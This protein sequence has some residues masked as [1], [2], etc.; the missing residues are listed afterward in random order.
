MVNTM[1]INDIDCHD[2]IEIGNHVFNHY[3]YTFNQDDPY[4]VGDLQKFLGN[5]GLMKIGKI[6]SKISDIIE[7]PF[8]LVEVSD[9]VNNLGTLKNGGP[10]K[11]TSELIKFIFKLCPTLLLYVCI[12]IASGEVGLS[13]DFLKRFVIFIRKPNSNKT[14]IKMLRPISLISNIVKLISHMNSLRIINAMVDSNIVPSFWNSYIKGKD[15]NSCLRTI[16]DNFE[17]SIKFNVKTVTIV[18]DI[19]S[20][21]DG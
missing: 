10:D 6:D 14:N 2:P 3:N 8:T 5:E 20:G 16:I 13:S 1:N 9:A 12:N 21:F 15:P 18:N 7:S 11:V 19:D 4:N 17:N